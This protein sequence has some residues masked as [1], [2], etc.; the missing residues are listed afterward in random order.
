MSNE[1]TDPRASLLRAA[2]AASGLPWAVARYTRK[3]F[4]L[5]RAGIDGGGAFFMLECVNDTTDDE[6]AQ[7]DAAYI[8]LACNMAP[9][10]LAA[11]TAAEGERDVAREER[12]ELMTTDVIALTAACG[13][14]RDSVAEL[15]ALCAEAADAVEHEPACRQW[16][17]PPVDWATARTDPSKC[18]CLVAR[19]RAAGGARPA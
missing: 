4:G 17:E 16:P 15:R 19:L 11:L 2:E 1:P 3:K 10:L 12:D 6:K 5:G 18:D 13:E 8:A 7:A 9:A 14:L